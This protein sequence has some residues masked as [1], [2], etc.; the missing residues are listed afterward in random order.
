[1]RDLAILR[2]LAAAALLASVAI[3]SEVVEGGPALCPFRAATGLPCPS[4]GMSRSWSAMGHGR[5]RDASTFH[6]MGPITFVAAAGLVVA[7]DER[8][9]RAI[10][11][12]P[13]SRPLIG[14]LATAWVGAW[15][16]RLARDTR[17]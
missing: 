2:R 16:W 7:G 15:L 13:S 5:L 10:E 4:C 17:A 11:G 8:V 9:S 1:M 12:R 6:L 14:A 3:P